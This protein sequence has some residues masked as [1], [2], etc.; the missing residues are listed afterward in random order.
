MATDATQVLAGFAD[1]LEYGDI[2]EATREYCKDILLDTL[3]C[4]I[5]GHQ[6]EETHQIAALASA[7]ARSDEST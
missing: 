7:L 3:A 6:G 5:A 4:A 1:F 2:P